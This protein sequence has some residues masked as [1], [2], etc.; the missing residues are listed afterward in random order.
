RDRAGN[1][2]EKRNGKGE[3]LLSLE[4]GPGNLKTVRRLA[5]GET[6]YF[7]YDQ[8]GRRLRVA[9]DDLEVRFA[10]DAYGHCVEGLRDGRGVRH[11][12][13]RHRLVETTVFGKFTTCYRHRADG[14]VVIRDPGGREHR[15]SLL[16]HG[17]VLRTLSNGSSEVS[18]FDAHGRCLMKVSS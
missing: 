1:L 18:Q 10:Y 12:F 11:R 9:T 13:D 4:V 2:I 17:L 15:L 16:G 3:V 6:H 5:S 14:T 8:R 7:E